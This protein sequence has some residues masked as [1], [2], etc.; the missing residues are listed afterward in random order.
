MGDWISIEN[1]LQAGRLPWSNIHIGEKPA[2]PVADKESDRAVPFRVVQVIDRQGD[3]AIDQCTD[4]SPPDLKSQPVP[5]ARANVRTHFVP[6]W[7]FGA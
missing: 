6:A 1:V 5:A 7:E 3:N 2:S 4:L